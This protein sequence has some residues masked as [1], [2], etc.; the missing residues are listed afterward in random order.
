MNPAPR[1]L[2]T[3]EHEAFRRTAGRS[4]SGRSCPHHEQWENDGQ[5]SREVWRGRGAG[6]ALLRRRRGVRRPGRR[7]TSATT[8]CSPRR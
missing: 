3:D 1:Q 6:P 4:S 5:V 7:R 8:W 2:L